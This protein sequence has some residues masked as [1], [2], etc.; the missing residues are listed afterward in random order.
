MLAAQASIV[1]RT[2][3]IPVRFLMPV[4]VADPFYPD[5]ISI[6]QDINSRPGGSYTAIGASTLELRQVGLRLS[7]LQQSAARGEL[8]QRIGVRSGHGLTH[9]RCRLAAHAQSS[10]A[11]RRPNTGPGTRR[12]QR[13]DGLNVFLRQE[14]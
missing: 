10:H 9:P 8:K 4:I 5:M 13:P 14:R 1:Q 6:M 7:G 11:G 3:T 12:P 2:E